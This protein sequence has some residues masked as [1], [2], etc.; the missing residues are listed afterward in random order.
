[1]PGSH[2]PRQEDV[3]RQ[4][5]RESPPPA[6]IASRPQPN[7]QRAQCRGRS[8]L[9]DSARPTAA[10]TRARLAGARSLSLV[11]L[12]SAGPRPVPFPAVGFGAWRG[13]RAV[14]RVARLW[15]SDAAKRPADA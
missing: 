14:E 6:A 8:K 2:R 9:V 1:M 5:R 11:K 15:D 7:L 13:W 10:W 4:S 12:V 3:D